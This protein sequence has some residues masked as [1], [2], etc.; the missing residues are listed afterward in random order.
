MTTFLLRYFAIDNVTYLK[1]LHS[2]DTASECLYFV[3]FVINIMILQA[4]QLRI[5]I[6]NTVTNYTFFLS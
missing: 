2:I 3:R 1:G 5:L 4:K 6:G